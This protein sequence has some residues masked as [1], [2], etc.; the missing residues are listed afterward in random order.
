MIGIQATFRT[1]WEADTFVT[2]VYRAYNPAGYGTNLSVCRVADGT[3]LVSGYR[4]SSC[5]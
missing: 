1:K 3:F 2:R 4:Y 5:D